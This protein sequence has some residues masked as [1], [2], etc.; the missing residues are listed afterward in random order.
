VTGLLLTVFGGITLELYG[1]TVPLAARVPA[2]SAT[3][4]PTLHNLVLPILFY[5][6][7]ALHLGGVVKHHF[8]AGRT[9][10]VRRMLR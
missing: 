5:A 9:D 3:L 6:V 4:W 7:M 2:A 8:I 1:W 10:D